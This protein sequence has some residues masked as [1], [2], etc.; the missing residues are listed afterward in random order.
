MERRRPTAELAVPTTRQEDMRHPAHVWTD[1]E[2]AKKPL[3]K[4]VT[5]YPNHLRGR[6]QPVSPETMDKYRKALLS[7]MRSME[8]QQIPLLLESLTPAAVNGWIQ[9]QRSMGRAEDGIASRLGAVKL[10]MLLRSTTDG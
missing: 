2:F 7:M 9:E 5:E 3:E 4:L 1:P 8:R 6:S 10:V